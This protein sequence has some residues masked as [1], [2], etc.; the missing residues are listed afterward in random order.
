MNEN[1]RNS[2]HGWVD[3]DDVP[4]LTGPE[5]AEAIAKAEVKRGRPK[6]DVTKV[7]TTIR[8]DA[9]VLEKFRATGPGWQRRINEVLK[10]AKP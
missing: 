10:A 4:D 3:P 2:D 7:S 9:D 1:R 5:W 8:L 6:A